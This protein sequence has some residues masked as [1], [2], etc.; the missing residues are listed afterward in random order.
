MN[1]DEG[2]RPITIRDLDRVYAAL[3][4]NASK[5]EKMSERMH[6]IELQMAVKAGESNAKA[7]V[8]DTKIA[9]IWA[10]ASAIGLGLIGWF[11]KEILSVI[12]P[13]TP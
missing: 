13:L 12:K 4:D 2:S 10:V 6:A 5:T 9:V 8:M 7:S 11:M 1:E 3:T